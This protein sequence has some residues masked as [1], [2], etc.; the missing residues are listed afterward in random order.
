MTGLSSQNLGATGAQP[1]NKENNTKKVLSTS[2]EGHSQ[3]GIQVP[4]SSA[5]GT[6]AASNATRA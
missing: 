6:T 1:A 5:S 3:A 4:P 2:G